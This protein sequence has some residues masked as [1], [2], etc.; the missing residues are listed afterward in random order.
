MLLTLVKLDERAAFRRWARTARIAADEAGDPVTQAWT[1]A[2]EAYGHYYSEDLSEAVT[3]AKQAQHVI[4]AA[5]GA[6]AALAAALEARAH[7]SLGQRQ[8]TLAALGRAGELVSTLDA[9]ALQ[10]SAFG[11]NEGQFRFHAGSAY[12]HLHDLSAAFAAQDRALELCS[13]GDYTDRALTRLDRASCFAY[14]GDVVLAA[15]EIAETLIGLSED[16]RRGIIELRAAEIVA[17]LPDRDQALPVVRDL[18]DLIA[19]A[20]PRE[21][22][23][24]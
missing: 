23:H 20:T 18:Q 13:P 6:G 16:Q 2:Q 14:D 3:V 5:V 21:D 8:E 11:Y 1:L 19:P 9:D 10:P 24:P 15:G 22:R 4:G 17:G 7:A 12:T